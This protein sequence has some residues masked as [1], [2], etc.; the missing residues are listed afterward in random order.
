MDV[1]VVDGV[2]E[3]SGFEVCGGLSGGHEVGAKSFSET[4]GFSYVDD[5]AEA[6]FHEV[7]ARCEGD[8]SEFLFEVCFR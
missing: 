7:D 4:F 3:C 2:D 6:I 5:T 8:G 1:E